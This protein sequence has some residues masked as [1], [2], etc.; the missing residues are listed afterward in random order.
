MP[1]SSY[2]KSLLLLFL[3]CCLSLG[4]SAQKKWQDLW[5]VEDVCTYMPQT[6]ERMLDQFDLSRPGLEK[7]QRARLDGD[8][9]EACK[10]LLT[11]YQEGATASYL[12][13][14]LPPASGKTVAE[15]DTI[16]EDVFTVLTIRGQ[17]PYL[18]DGHRDWYYKGPNNDREWAWLSNRHP[19]II[20]TLDAY[21]ETGNPKYVRYI[22]DFLRDFIL[23]K[24]A[25][26]SREK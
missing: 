12:R 3:L 26:S 17:L 10:A 9:V 7:V 25:V 20:A 4:V 19:Q 2:P 18:P 5:T 1:F 15:A 8:L 6:M 21:F 13:K 22:D 14:T 11:Y 23:D 24:Y 16:L